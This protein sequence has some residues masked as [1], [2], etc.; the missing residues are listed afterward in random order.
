MAIQL[1]AVVER[2]GPLKRTNFC[3]QAAIDQQQH[4]ST[5]QTRVVSSAAIL[6]S[7]AV[8]PEGLIAMRYPRL[9]EPPKSFSASSP[10]RLGHNED[11]RPAK[12]LE[13]R[14]QLINFAGR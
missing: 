8:G 13:K 1:G 14:S 4:A 5:N 11:I 6:S 7:R 10:G 12:K 2:G 3:A 9:I